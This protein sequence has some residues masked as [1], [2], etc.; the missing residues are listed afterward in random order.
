ML[1]CRG[2]GG[3]CNG[4]CLR[5]NVAWHFHNPLFVI[6][7]NDGYI[8]VCSQCLQYTMKLLTVDYP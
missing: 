2:W 8:Q 4:P 6:S 5:E 3:R 1:N 7:I